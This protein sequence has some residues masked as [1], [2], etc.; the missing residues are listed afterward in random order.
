MDDT[1]KKHYKKEYNKLLK[2]NPTKEW[3]IARGKEAKMWEKPEEII[4]NFK[5]K[6]PTW[7][8]YMEEILKK[9]A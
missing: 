6:D 2:D 5:K 4:E 7:A 3:I 1:F 8:G 9:A